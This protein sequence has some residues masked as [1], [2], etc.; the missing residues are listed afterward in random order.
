MACDACNN[1][2][3]EIDEIFKAVIGNI[4]HSSWDG[5][6]WKS[7]ISTLNNNKKLDSLLEKHSRYEEI[8]HQN[9]EFKPAKILKLDNKLKDAF[10]MAM[11]R[12]AK[13]LFY[14][15]YNEVLVLRRD[16]SLFLPD[17]IHP[18]KIESIKRNLAKST[19]HEIN[20][21]TCR[22]VFVEMDNK[23]IVFIIDLYD[24]I[25][26]HYVIQIKR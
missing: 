24:A 22:Y 9:G 14:Q 2:S 8:E 17:V 21:G 23:D 10:L 1:G 18:N 25:K 12:I 3:S 5:E 6:L 13:G 11:E 4:A 26:L 16:I 19:L 7:T 15:H 20:K